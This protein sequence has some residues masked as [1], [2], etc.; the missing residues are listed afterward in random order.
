MSPP[1]GR[2]RTIGRRGHS[3]VR[4]AVKTVSSSA[5]AETPSLARSAVM[6]AGM[7]TYAIAA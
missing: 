4:A 6:K 3:A 7:S 2:I 1:Q 5:R